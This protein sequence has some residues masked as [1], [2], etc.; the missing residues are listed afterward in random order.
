[1]SNF[2]F[3][4]AAEWPVIQS[5]CARAESYVTSDPRSACI[6]ARRGIEQLVGLLYDLLDL[7]APYKDDLSARMNEPPFRKAVP[8]NI[9]HKFNLIRKA[10][11]AA[12]HD[13]KPIAPQLALGVLRE[14]HHVMVWAVFNHSAYPKAAPL[15][16]PFDPKLAAK[17]AP[18]TRQEATQLA[19]KFAAQDEA[20]AKE[21][22]DKDELAAQK[23]AEIAALREAVKQ[24][25]AANKQ[26]DNRDYNEAETRDTF[27][28]LMLAEAGWPLDTAKDRE[29]PV[30]GMPNGDGKGFVDY[31]LWG[32]DGL[33]LAIVEAK[34]TTKSPQIGQPQA[35][36]YADCLEQMT[37]RR[38]IIFYTNG[39]EHWIWDDAGGYAP[40]E[41]QG[42]YTRDELELMIQRRDTRKTLS[43]M[44]IDSA[45]VERHYQHRAI[46]AIDDAF[47]AKQ[48][49]ALLVM[50]TGV[51][52]DPHRHRPSETADGSQLGQARAVPGRPYGPGH[53]GRQRLQSA[54]TGCHHRQPGDR[55]DHRRPGLRMHVPDDDEPDQR[56]RLWHKEIRS[57]LLRPGRHRRSPSL[58]VPEVPGHLRMVRLA[59]RRADRHP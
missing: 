40:R 47:T 54:P 58:G 6:Y 36:L 12:V 51:G 56:H 44:P 23:D 15:Q 17:A 21:L 35:K 41:I 37:G 22:A 20:H 10:G 14:L 33:P 8:S 57:R 11:N 9:T 25:Q 19:A 52:K 45:I 53:P 49:E 29:Y 50:A 28:D 1:M 46:R 43:E 31:V 3:L 13:Q 2:A 5:D 39:F 30:T 48:R 59:A 55:E 18:L 26:P 38:P 24:A 7:P 32:S 34:R 16:L 27:I 42:F 4:G